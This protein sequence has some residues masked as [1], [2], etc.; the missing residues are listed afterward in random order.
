[1]I[2]RP[3][4]QIESSN[5]SMTV[6]WANLPF[7]SPSHLQWPIGWGEAHWSIHRNKNQKGRWNTA[8][9]K[10]HKTDT[11]THHIISYHIISYHTHMIWYQHI[12]QMHKTSPFTLPPKSVPLCEEAWAPS[13]IYLWLFMYISPIQWQ[14][15]SCPQVRYLNKKIIR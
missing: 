6:T 15:N 11:H 9:K 7:G 13:N 2:D 3:I 8:S 1:M 10:N 4:L 12:Y 14:Q 5:P